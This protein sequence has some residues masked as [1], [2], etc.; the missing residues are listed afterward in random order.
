VINSEEEIT[1]DKIEDIAY[2]SY[3][4]QEVLRRDGAAVISFYYKVK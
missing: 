4:I 2:L 3:F 1:K